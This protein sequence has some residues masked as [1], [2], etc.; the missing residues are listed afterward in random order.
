MV[1]IGNEIGRTKIMG[2][3]VSPP[4]ATC[5]EEHLMF[6]NY[7]MAGFRRIHKYYYANGLMRIVRQI[8]RAVFL[9]PAKP[10][11]VII[12]KH[13]VLPLICR[14]WWT[15]RLRHYFCPTNFISYLDHRYL[16][17]LLKNNYMFVAQFNVVELICFPFALS[18]IH[19][20]E[21]TRPY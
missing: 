3:S 14:P 7:H 15:H 6:G 1:Q 10:S 21:P 2:R 19:I 20:S 16:P 12:T 17:I 5:Q 8:E 9:I 11:H 13:E 4:G 18:L